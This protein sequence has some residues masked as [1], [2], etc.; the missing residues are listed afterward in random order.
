MINVSRS[1]LRVLA[2]ILAAG[3]ASTPSP[4]T[5][6]FE[7]STRHSRRVA[8]SAHTWDQEIDRV[9]FSVDGRRFFVQSNE[10]SVGQYEQCVDSGHCLS[11]FWN[12]P[13]TYRTASCNYGTNMRRDHPMNCVRYLEA[14][15]YC[16][17][18][19][20]RLPT[21]SEWQMAAYGGTRTYPW[22][23]DPPS[24][25]R[26]NARSEQDDVGD[27]ANRTRLDSWTGTSPVGSFPLGATPD[28][29]LDVAGNV[30]E[31]VTP[32]AIYSGPFEA[33]VIHMGGSFIDTPMLDRFSKGTWEWAYRES[34]GA[35]IGFRCAWD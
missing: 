2:V 19:G 28:G 32:D 21:A 11:P 9:M 4:G 34:N 35:E 15:L 8:P 17:F 13:P 7:E 1:A 14:Y 30:S 6:G 3:C 31:W 16:S 10:V 33:S 22:G 26:L 24:T 23:D 12:C 20:G 18:V 25:E 29:L 27:D 5:S